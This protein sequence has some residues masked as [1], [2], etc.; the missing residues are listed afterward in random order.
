MNI[1]EQYV[2][3]GN[4]I[5]FIFISTWSQTRCNVRVAANMF[6]LKFKLQHAHGFFW[7]NKYVEVRKRHTFADGISL[8]T[9]GW[10][11][12]EQWN[13]KG[14]TVRPMHAYMYIYTWEVS[15]YISNDYIT[16]ERAQRN[17][18]IYIYIPTYIPTYIHTYLHTY[19]PTCIHTYIHIMWIFDAYSLYRNLYSR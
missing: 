17:I 10:I 16:V 11:E 3:W 7:H 6:K 8:V 2:N 12:L 18:H 4:N 15:N 13:S 14:L 5:N 9:R 1:Y 19:L